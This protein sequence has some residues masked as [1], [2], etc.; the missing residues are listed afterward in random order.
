MTTIASTGYDFVCS[1]AKMK[2][3]FTAF[4]NVVEAWPSDV[5]EASVVEGRLLG[6]TITYVIDPEHIRTLLVNEA[7]KLV[8]DEAMTRSLAPVL[9]TG[10]L[11]S[12]GQTWQAQR[13]IT[14]PTFRPERI[15]SFIPAITRAA[16]ATR[17]RW[18]GGRP[19]RVIDLQS[20]MM[21][22]TLDVITAT[23]VSGEEGFDPAAFG[24]ALDAYLGQ[25]NWKIAYGIAGAPTWL[26]HPGSMTGMRASR[27]LRSMTSRVI[28]QRRRSG[29][30]NDDLL[31]MMLTATDPDTEETF[32][33]ERLIDNLLTFVMAGHETTALAIA[34]TL[35]LV[36]GH[37]AVEQ[38]VLDEIA[39]LTSPLDA[40]DTLDELVYTRQ[41]LLEA[42]RLFPPAALLVRRAKEE[43]WL[44]DTRI[45]A[46]RSIHV[47]VYALH[48]H[49]R[50]WTHPDTFD[51]D[52][53]EPDLHRSRHRF[54]FLPFGGGRRVC[55]GMGLAITECLV[56]LA[57]LLPHI[58]LHPVQPDL[59]QTHLRVTLRPV[60]GLPVTVEPRVSD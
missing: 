9:G 50:L 11:T 2:S 60:G 57:T 30:Q 59:P 6:R 20:E 14:A 31:G 44:G 27:T 13:R 25:T 24:A 26:P 1:L 58:R 16:E 22:T 34:W 49:R 42:M 3:P 52:R 45:P 53:F 18:Q 35:R 21:R 8:R 5:Y 12:D 46:G 7:H 56:V 15:R 47:P 55:I 54:A 39:S 28:Q 4:R 40:A 37:P 17:R 43:L 41:V 38:R 23:T 48:R 29:K 10:L 36:A 32:D 33:D 19:G 51:P